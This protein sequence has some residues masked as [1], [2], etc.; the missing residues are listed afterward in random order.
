MIKPKIGQK[1]TIS[2]TNWPNKLTPVTKYRS[3][4]VTYV[5]ALDQCEGYNVQIRSCFFWKYDYYIDHRLNRLGFDSY[6]ELSES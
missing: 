1:V 2:S 5:R 3:G 6:P 4:R